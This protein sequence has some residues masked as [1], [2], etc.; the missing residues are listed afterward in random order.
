KIRGLNSITASSNPLYVI[1]GIPQDHM[2]NVNPRDIASIEVLKDASS[3]AIY[4]AR[5]GNG[6]VVITTKSGA[7]GATQVDFHSYAGYQGVDRFL[8]MMDTREDTAYIRYLRDS[9]FQQTG[10]DL[11]LPICSRPAEYQYP[12]AYLSPAALPDNNWQD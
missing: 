4:G 7:S 12:E 10:G 5:G 6:V 11:S 2:R 3:A 8:P 1:D 9:R